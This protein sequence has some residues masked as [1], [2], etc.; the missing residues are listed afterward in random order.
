MFTDVS[1]Q[2]PQEAKNVLGHFAY[3]AEGA[4]RLNL[5][6]GWRVRVE[7]DGLDIE[8][9]FWYGS[10]TNTRYIGGMPL[11][12]LL[13]VSLDD[14][15]FE[16]M[17]VRRPQNMAELQRLLTC[18]MTQKPDGD[19]LHFARTRRA[20]LHFSSET[21]F[22]LDGEAGPTERDVQIEVLE[23]GMALLM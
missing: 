20:A 16:L 23:C 5:A 8:D 22:T 17:L 13:K 14:G 7:A 21:P 3:I 11:P 10:V 19:L 6:Q 18:L 1:Y 4:R 2:T 9:E 15:L 12:E